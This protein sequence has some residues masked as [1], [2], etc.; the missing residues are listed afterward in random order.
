MGLEKGF[1]IEDFRKVVEGLNPFV[2]AAL[3]FEQITAYLQWSLTKID[4]LNLE[5]ELVRNEKV[6]PENKL[7][8]RWAEIDNFKTEIKSL[9]K[10]IKELQSENSG[11]EDRLT[12]FESDQES[13]TKTL[14][15]YADHANWKDGNIWHPHDWSLGRYDGDELAN[16]ALRGIH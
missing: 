3:S 12:D 5:V 4:S 11:L 8:D 2:V 1:D 15:K 10:E 7:A 9:K 13:A 6:D 14:E 16:K